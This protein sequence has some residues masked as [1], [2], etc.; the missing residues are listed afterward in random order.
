M[1]VR[2]TPSPRV[3]QAAA[4][5]AAGLLTACSYRGELV[6]ANAEPPASARPEAHALPPPFEA[7]PWRPIA[8]TLKPTTSRQIGNQ[9]LYVRAY[10]SD[11]EGAGT[12]RPHELYL[13]ERSITAQ[14][15][16]LRRAPAGASNILVLYASS[17]E[18]SRLTRL[19]VSI[20]GGSIIG[21]TLN[22]NDIPVAF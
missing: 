2:T 16:D 5:A 20:S 22:T 11:C 14:P 13:G 12:G 10:L 15:S 17:A 4:V 7:G 1:L 6:S 19:C 8:V 18:I 21:A 3:R 9:E